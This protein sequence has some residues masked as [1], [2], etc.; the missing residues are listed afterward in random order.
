MYRLIGTLVIVA[1][2]ISPGGSAAAMQPAGSSPSAPLQRYVTL[3]A[4]SGHGHGLSGRRLVSGSVVSGSPDECS[5]KTYELDR[6]SYRVVG[7]FEYYFVAG[8]APW[9]LDL[10][11]TEAAMEESVL[12]WT[13]VHDN[14]GL[15]DDVSLTSAYKGRSSGSA[16]ITSSGRCKDGSDGRS[17]TD[18]G[19]LPVG[20]VAITCVWISGSRPPYTV[21]SADVRLNKAKNWWNTLSTCSGRRYIVEA[22]LTHERGHVFGLAHGTKVIEAS[23]GNLTMSPTIDGYCQAAEATLGKGDVRGIRARGY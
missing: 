8:S 6:A 22:A 21:E 13:N 9:Y 1:A 10:G 15:A 17:E 19:M 16:E 14:C 2:A 12:N 11:K 23:H 4:P 7:T 5:D 20:M 3:T 18:F